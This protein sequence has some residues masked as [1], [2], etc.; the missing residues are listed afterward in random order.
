MGYTVH[1]GQR[2]QQQ[3]TFQDVLQLD[4]KNT[5]IGMFSSLFLTESDKK[6]SHDTY[7]HCMYSKLARAMIEATNESCTVPWILENQNICSDSKDIN[8]A[9]WI[10]WNRITNQHKDCLSP[11]HATIVN[12]GM[13]CFYK[14]NGIL[15]NTL[16]CFNVLLNDNL[17]FEI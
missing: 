16:L 9:F 13:Y 2:I 5:N 3:I 7:D 8:T 11:C 14:S 12:V 15:H 17:L 1:S 6:C 10:A 4:Y